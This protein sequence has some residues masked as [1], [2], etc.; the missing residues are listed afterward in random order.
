MT[1]SCYTNS[2]VVATFDDVETGVRSYVRYWSNVDGERTF[3]AVYILDVDS[4]NL[5]PAVT[6]FP[7]YERAIHYAKQCVGLEPVGP[8]SWTV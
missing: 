4:G 3:F 5:L 6:Q 7:D 2:E 1:N 8:I